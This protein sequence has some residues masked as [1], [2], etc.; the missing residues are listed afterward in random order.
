MRPSMYTRWPSALGGINSTP[1]D[2]SIAGRLASPPAYD[3]SG[4]TIGVTASAG[5][6]LGSFDG[7]TDA[8][9]GSGVVELDDADADA[10]ADADS[11]EGADD[12]DEGEV[13]GADVNADASTDPGASFEATTIGADDVADGDRVR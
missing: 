2:G 10:D 4:V 8:S 6:A 5:R 11:D 3:A 13:G 9:V 1:F 7:V 12:V